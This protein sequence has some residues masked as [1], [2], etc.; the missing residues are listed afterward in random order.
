MLHISDGGIWCAIEVSAIF[1][2]KCAFYI[3]MVL[4]IK[5]VLYINHLHYLH[6]YLR[7]NGITSGKQFNTS[8][9][10]CPMMMSR[11]RCGNLIIQWMALPYW[12]MVGSFRSD[13][14][15]FWDFR[16]NWVSILFLTTTWLTPSIYKK[17]ISLSLSHLV[18]E[19]LRPKVGLFVLAKCIN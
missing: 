10:W 13:D 2:Q 6:V 3:E 7:Q 4:D 11:L 15:R 12:G 14:S 9:V 19:K 18:L 1:V 5:M 16:S 17:K 8:F